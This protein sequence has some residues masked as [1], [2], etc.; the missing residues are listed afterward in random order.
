VLSRVLLRDLILGMGLVGAAIAANRPGTGPMDRAIAVCLLAV[1]IALWRW[2]RDP[3]PG[4]P[5]RQR[6]KDGPG[7]IGGPGG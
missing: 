3:T 5:A 7:T 6:R 1:L 2:N 4:D